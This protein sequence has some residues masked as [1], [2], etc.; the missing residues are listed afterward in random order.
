[1]KRLVDPIMI[2]YAKEIGAEA[3]LERINA[4]K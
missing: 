1:M 4:V 3:I 2:A